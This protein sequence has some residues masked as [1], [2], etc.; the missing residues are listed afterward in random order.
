MDIPLTAD[1]SRKVIFGLEKETAT[2][3]LRQMM[4]KIENGEL[5]VHKI[6]VSTTDQAEDFRATTFI[7]EYAPTYPVEQ[8]A[9]DA[10]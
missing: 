2:K 8:A 5:I 7:V 3:R 9:P 10:V 4:E 6:V 1:P